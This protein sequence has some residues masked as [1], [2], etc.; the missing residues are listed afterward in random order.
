[1]VQK[2]QRDTLDVFLPIVSR[3]LS[4]THDFCKIIELVDFGFDEIPVEEWK[5]V[6]AR[7]WNQFVYPQYEPI[8]YE[9]FP[10]DLK[11]KGQELT[12]HMSIIEYNKKM[13][14]AF[15]EWINR[16]GN[17][18]YFDDHIFF[19]TP[20]SININSL[21]LDGAPFKRYPI[22]YAPSLLQKLSEKCNV[23]D[24]ERQK[25]SNRFQIMV[26]ILGII[27]FIIGSIIFNSV[28]H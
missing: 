28:T 15:C 9:L 26:F 24:R 2:S 12:Q 14:I 20:N 3:A 19:V 11:L 10:E 22:E 7:F 27:V 25:N 6:K 1:M 8:Y 21:L 23:I 13:A 5:E 18:H 4:K 17:F 16:N